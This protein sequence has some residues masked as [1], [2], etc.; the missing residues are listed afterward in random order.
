PAKVLVRG[1]CLVRIEYCEATLLRQEIYAC[2]RSE[3][4]RRLRT[5]MQHDDE[6]D[7]GS[8]R[9][10]FRSIDTIRM[11]AMSILITKLLPHCCFPS[12]SKQREAGDVDLGRSGSASRFC[13]V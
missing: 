7:R 6:R 4:E 3:V 1:P 11:A 2:P 9:E 8:K 12:L 13:L 10:E 5:A